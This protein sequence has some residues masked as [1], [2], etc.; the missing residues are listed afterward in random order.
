MHPRTLYRWRAKLRPVLDALRDRPRSDRG[1][2]RVIR[3]TAAAYALLIIS[4]KPRKNVAEI[5]RALAHDWTRIGGEGRP[6]SYN[7]VRRFV[8]RSRR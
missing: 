8:E 5:R 6:P 4:A 3:G 7:A 2:S 1:S